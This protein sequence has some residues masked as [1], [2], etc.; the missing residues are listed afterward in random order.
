MKSRAISALVFGLCFGFIFMIISLFTPPITSYQCGGTTSYE[1]YGVNIGSGSSCTGGDSQETIG[2]P[3]P[4][5][6]KYNAPTINYGGLGMENP[7]TEMEYNPAGIVG[8]LFAYWALG[9]LFFFIFS[10]SR[11]KK[12]PKQ[13]Q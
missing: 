11:Q 3:F 6:K 8:N 5:Q 13:T 10:R 12:T 7:S 1:I 2:F 4:S 9:F